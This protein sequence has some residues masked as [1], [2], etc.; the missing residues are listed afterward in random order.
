MRKPD[1]KLAAFAAV[2]V[3]GALTAGPALAQGHDEKDQHGKME[4]HEPAPAREPMKAHEQMQRREPTARQGQARQMEHFADQHRAAIR[5]YYAQHYRR[6]CPPG[7][8]KT[9]RGCEPRV[10]ERRW[11]RGK[12]LPRDVVFYD[13]PPKLAVEIGA[14]PAGYRYVRVASDILLIAAGTG[15]VVDAINDLGR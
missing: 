8:E 9:A 14:P 7:L 3:A 15:L 6:H 11:E 12:P 1:K 4:R 5:D 10:A 13:L 2:L